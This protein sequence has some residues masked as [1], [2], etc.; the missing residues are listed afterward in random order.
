MGVEHSHESEKNAYVGQTARE[1]DAKM[2]GMLPLAHS[3]TNPYSGS[4][5][6][7]SRYV[8]LTL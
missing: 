3:T 4:R 2:Q 5:S 1:Q 8:C 7:N 6:G